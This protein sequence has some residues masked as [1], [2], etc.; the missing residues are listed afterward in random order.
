MLIVRPDVGGARRRRRHRAG[1][2]TYRAGARGRK[3]RGGPQ[4][5]DTSPVATCVL[6]FTA[7]A[8]WPK[9]L[10]QSPRVTVVRP[11]VGGALRRRRRRA[12]A[13]TYRAGARGRK[14]RGG[15]QT[16]D[17]S[18]VATCVLEFTALAQWPKSLPQSPRV[19]VVRPDVGGALRRRRR[20]AGAVTYRA[21]ARGRK[22]R[23]NPQ[24]SDTNA[25]S[26]PA[27]L[28]SLHSRGGPN[29]YLSH[30]E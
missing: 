7:L 15:P 18:P 9:S 3:R 20:R 25:Q 1:A 10:P 13:V 6:E 26:R 4:T 12:G 19:T 5:S 27:Y 23:G 29:H 21:G 2:V 24:T 17:T 22:R 11:D 8:Q 14:R 30:L 28:S 16:S